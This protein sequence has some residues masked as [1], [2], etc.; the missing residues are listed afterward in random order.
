MPS[1]PTLPTPSG[2]DEEETFVIHAGF[3]V[4][5]FEVRSRGYSGAI[6]SWI[7]TH[8]IVD[9]DV[10]CGRWRNDP[11]KHL[12]LHMSVGGAERLV[13]IVKASVL[14]GGDAT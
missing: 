13:S 9:A 7:N 3:T 12:T 6:S 8:G 10:V 2:S 11:Y 14:T 1:A 4:G 5:L